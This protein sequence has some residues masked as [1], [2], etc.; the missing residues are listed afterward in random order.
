MLSNS[1]ERR[2]GK[3]VDGEEVRCRA[4]RTSCHTRL[5]CL[6]KRDV[7]RLRVT[8]VPH[9]VVIRLKNWDGMS[10]APSHTQIGR[11]VEDACPYGDCA[12][13]SSGT[14]TPTVQPYLDGS[15]ECSPTI[16]VLCL[17]SI[18]DL[19]VVAPDATSVYTQAS[20]LSL[21]TFCVRHFVPRF[22]AN[23]RE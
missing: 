2:C 1:K 5:V 10:K 18:Q 3:I 4:Y 20:S 11:T 17:R 16:E 15:T 13:G 7:A 6:L 9:G 8:S 12:D 23:V 22:F 21:V 19:S 14:P